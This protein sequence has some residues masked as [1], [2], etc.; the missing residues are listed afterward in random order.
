MDGMGTRST[1]TTGKTRYEAIHNQEVIN[2]QYHLLVPARR[3]RVWTRGRMPGVDASLAVWDLA[4]RTLF[5]F[6]EPKCK[7]PNGLA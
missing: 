7:N 6:S 5:F 4:K 1:S 2:N 3:I